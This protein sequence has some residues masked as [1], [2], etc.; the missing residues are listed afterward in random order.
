MR[1]IF[2]LIL[3]VLCE[4]GSFGQSNPKIIHI[5]T[6]TLV[7]LNSDSKSYVLSDSLEYETLD[8]GHTD[9]IVFS[10]VDSINFKKFEKFVDDF[11][12]KAWN[13]KFIL[14]AIAEKD[15]QQKADFFLSFYKNRN[16]NN[17]IRRSY[18]LAVKESEAKFK[19]LNF[20]HILVKQ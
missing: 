15:S 5:S 12:R 17:S 8:I 20:K 1:K 7:S 11:N 16:S 4:L 6:S 13:S 9:L 10:L 19:K 2:F 3:V 14:F 18:K